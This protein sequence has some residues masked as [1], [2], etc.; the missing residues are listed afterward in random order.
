MRQKGAAIKVCRE[1]INY[2]GVWNK[3]IGDSTAWEEA[4]TLKSTFF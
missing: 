2:K 3:C 4:M 1:K